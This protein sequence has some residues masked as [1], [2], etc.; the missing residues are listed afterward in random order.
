MTAVFEF[1]VEADG[2]DGIEKVI[3]GMMLAEALVARVELELIG[4]RL[5][6]NFG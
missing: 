4:V 1:G 6:V 2:K 3:L 5:K